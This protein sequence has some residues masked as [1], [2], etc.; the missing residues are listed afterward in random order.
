MH[1]RSF[2]TV[3][4]AGTAFAA[5]RP[6]F[7]A[8]THVVK[9]KNSGA[10]GAMVFEPG[11]LKVKPGDSIRF[12]ATDPGHNAETI[13]GMT[14][15]PAIPRG[16]MGKD[17]VVTLTQQGVYGFK[18]A[19]HLSM[20]MVCLIQVGKPVNRAAAEAAAA[21]T[22]NLARKRFANYFAKVS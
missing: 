1:R 19:P 16:P 21:K 17:H 3:L 10:E 6:A 2:L 18:C 12:A 9:M 7:A 5:A 15:G 8:T 13:A 11:F 20:G 14:P 4:L 22:P